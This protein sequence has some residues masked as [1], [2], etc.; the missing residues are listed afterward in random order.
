MNNDKK[1]V[2]NKKEKV[3]QN[4]KYYKVNADFNYLKNFNYKVTKEIGRGG[5]GVVYKVY[6]FLFRPPIWETKMLNVL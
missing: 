6:H 5:Y 2:G 3:A 4:D 1:T